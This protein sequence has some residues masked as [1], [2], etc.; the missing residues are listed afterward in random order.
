MKKNDIQALQ[1]LEKMLH[2]LQ[3][4][5]QSENRSL[6]KSGEFANAMLNNKG[7]D[8]FKKFK[9]SKQQQ[10]SDTANSLLELT[11]PLIWQ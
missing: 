1:P 9:D 11:V 4:S 6:N 3:A 2:L 7:L 10:V 8:T 5:L